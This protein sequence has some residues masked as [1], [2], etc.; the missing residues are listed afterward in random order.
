[1]KY[2]VRLEITNS[3]NDN[4]SREWKF[5]DNEEERD[6]WIA[7]KKLEELQWSRM[8]GVVSTRYYEFFPYNSENILNVD[9]SELAGMTL[10][11]FLTEILAQELPPRVPYRL[12]PTGQ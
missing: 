7:Q 12:Y 8:P 3:V 5:F 10:R 2:L 11:D 9:V 4:T 6:V 1:M